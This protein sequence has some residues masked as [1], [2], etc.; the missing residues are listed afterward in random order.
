[1]LFYLVAYALLIGGLAITRSIAVF[2]AAGLALTVFGVLN[3]LPGLAVFVRR[4]HDTDRSGWWFWIGLIPWLGAIILFAFLVTE[5]SPGHNRY[6]P[7]VGRPPA[8][9]YVE[10]AGWTRSEALSRFAADAQRAAAEGYQPVSQ[11]WQ[12]RGNVEVL[13]VWYARQGQL[14]WPAPPGPHQPS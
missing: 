9:G 5:G 12:Q 4:L 2:G 10:Y 14:T 8:E 13:R 7:P 11:D 6:G 3:I 1:M